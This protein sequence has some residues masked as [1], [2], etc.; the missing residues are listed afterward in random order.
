MKIILAGGGTAGHINPAIAIAQEILKHNK[1]TEILFVGNENAMEHTIALKNGFPFKSIKVSGFQRSFKLHNI[2]RNTKAVGHLLT[3]KKKCK[4]ILREFEPD[5]VIGTGGYVSGPIVFTASKMGY[6]TI[7]H[8]QNA[9]PGITTKILSKYV[10][11]VMLTTKEAINFINKKEK[12]VVTGL[13]LRCGILD[14]SEIVAK[15]KYGINGCITILSFGGSLGAKPLNDAI[16]KLIKWEVDNNQN[17]LHI[18][19]T[20]RNGYTEFIN[21]LK[22]FGI[23]AGKNNLIIKEYINDMDICMKSS[24]IVISRSGATTLSEITACGKASILIPSPYVTEN[25]QYHN[26]KVLSDNGASILIEEKDLEDTTLINAV[27]DLINNRNK[28]ERFRV[29]AKKL[30]ILDSNQKIYRIIEKTLK[31]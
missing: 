6:K 5:L 1:D 31:N 11:V 17:I 12:C 28:L 27:K 26:A 23:D 21:K 7:I 30:A 25:H 13:P 4:K 15:S 14:T 22:N 3:V 16:V 8:E 20:G 24:D 9:Y 10:D 19:S 18:H 29:N 2:K